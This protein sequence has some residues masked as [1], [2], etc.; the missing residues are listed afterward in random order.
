MPASR[1]ADFYLGCLVGAVFLD[2]DCSGE[3]QIYLRRISFD[4]YGCCEL[5]EETQPLNAK[6]SKEFL[7][8]LKHDELDQERI[9]LS[10]KR[11]ININ[12]ENIWLDALEQYGLV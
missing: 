8:L 9:T 2:F 5:P 12:K 1:K 11:I 4:G 3:S 10:V 6:G 7:E